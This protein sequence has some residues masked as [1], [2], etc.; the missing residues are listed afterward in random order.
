A[1]GKRLVLCRTNEIREAALAKYEKVV[2]SCTAPSKWI[3][4]RCPEACLND[5]KAAIISLGTVP[6]SDGGVP[7]DENAWKQ[8]VQRLPGASKFDTL[9]GSQAVERINDGLAVA[10]QIHRGNVVRG[11]VTKVRT[12][13]V[14]P[15]LVV[16]K[17]EAGNNIPK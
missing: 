17:V 11:Q 3:S 14:E 15:A 7:H 16:G 13:A 10:L 1:L 12:N 2:V 6:T 5:S 9:H 4:G 8:Q